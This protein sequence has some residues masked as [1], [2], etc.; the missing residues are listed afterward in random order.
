MWPDAATLAKLTG[1]RLGK[2]ATYSNAACVI[3]KWFDLMDDPGAR[4]WGAS[5][6]G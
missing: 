5:G 2:D 4:H 6:D 1:V 3:A